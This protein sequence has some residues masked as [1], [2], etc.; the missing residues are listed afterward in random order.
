MYAYLKF[1]HKT[2]NSVVFY[3]KT[4]KKRFYTEGSPFLFFQIEKEAAS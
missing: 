4:L 3:G 1:R 2:D